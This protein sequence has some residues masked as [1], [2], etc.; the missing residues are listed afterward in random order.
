[1]AWDHYQREIGTFTYCYVV[2]RDT[3]KEARNTGTTTSTQKGD[4]EAAD[5]I[6]KVFGVESGSYSP[7]YMDKFRRNF[8]AGWGGYPLV[9]TPE[10]VT[11]RIVELSKTGVDGSLI[12][13]V[14]YNQELPYF[15]AKVLP[16][17]EQAGLRKSRA[18]ADARRQTAT[19]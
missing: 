10:Q 1:M 8:I 11:E 13:M 6:C 4:W 15:N 7:D 17:I 19:A 2:V 5:N 16:L 14:D 18:K 3:E 9:G 12:T